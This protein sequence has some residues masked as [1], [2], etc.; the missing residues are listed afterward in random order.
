LKSSGSHSLSPSGLLP[1]DSDQH[2]QIPV[3]RNKS[4]ARQLERA[5]EPENYPSNG[6]L[7][8]SE[9]SRGI[10][11]E[12]NTQGTDQVMV[13]KMSAGNGN[14]FFSGLRKGK[15]AR[16]TPEKAIT[17]TVSWR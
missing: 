6:V 10:R 3:R 17:I 2:C 7:S 14:K 13:K 12:D 9:L 11:E 8:D 16:L 4:E 5:R 1:N 15:A